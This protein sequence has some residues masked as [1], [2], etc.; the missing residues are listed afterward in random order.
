MANPLS[1]HLEV[2]R[3]HAAIGL[4]DT[5]IPRLDITVGRGNTDRAP[6]LYRSMVCFILQGAKHVAIN[7]EAPQLRLLAV[8]D[9]RP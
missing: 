3:R 5:P 2:V 8:P 9:Q 1:P 4:T 7:D 6:C